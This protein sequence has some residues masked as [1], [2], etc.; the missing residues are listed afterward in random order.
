VGYPNPDRSHFSSMDIWHTARRD[1]ESMRRLTG[2]LGRYLDRRAAGGEAGKDTQSP[3]LHL[4]AERQ[5]L[6]VVAQNVRVPSVSSIDGFKLNTGNDAAFAAAVEA[7]VAARRADAQDNNLIQFLQSSTVT[8]IASSK[9]MQDA[10]QRYKTDVKYPVTSLGKKLQTTAQ[11]IDA[12]FSTRIYY[13]ELG[14][15]DTHSNQAPT[16]A[17]QLREFSD[18]VAAFIKDI[19]AHGYGERV[20]VLSFSEFGRRLKENA[21]RGTDHGAAAP[22]FLAGAR[23]KPGLIGTH[24]SLTD[25]DSGDVKHHTDFRQIYATILDQWLKTDSKAVLGEAFKPVAALQ[26]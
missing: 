7:A 19:K 13:V 12:G 10:I 21:S 2:W 9:Q 26:M 14:G 6:A 1:V 23:V 16:H 24:P 25:L 11:L 4:G 18:A 20:L 5:P 22:L 15:F 3:A 8:A 17:A